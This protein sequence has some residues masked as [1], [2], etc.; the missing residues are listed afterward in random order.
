MYPFPHLEYELANGR[1]NILDSYASNPPTNIGCLL[2]NPDGTCSNCANG[3]IQ[4][5]GSCLPGVK[6][7]EEY[8]SD[9]TCKQ[10]LTEYSLIFNECKHN[11]LLGCK[12][13]Q[14][15]HTCSECHKPYLLD[16]YRCTIKQCKSYNDF[17]CIS[18]ECGYYLTEQRNCQK[19]QQGCLKHYRGVCVNCLPHYKLKGGSCVIDGCLE[20][21]SQ[22]C[23][24]CAADYD[25]VDG[26]CQFKDCLEW[27]DDSCSLCK[28]GF[29]LV[30]GKCQPSAGNFV[31]QG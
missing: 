17:G 29:N 27:Q 18:C 7:C 12:V 13:E 5:S 23:Q 3:F 25:L 24:S 10:C 26:L 2:P 20:Y 6:N 30:Q 4:S 28:Q 15:D 11:Y 14:A 16:S 9:N 8:N 22:F 21:Q 1:C 19:V 31:C